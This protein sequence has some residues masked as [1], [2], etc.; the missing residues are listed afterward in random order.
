[1]SSSSKSSSSESKQ[2]TSN[3]SSSDETHATLKMRVIPDPPA[4][5]HP[6][7]SLPTTSHNGSTSHGSVL[8]AIELVTR[9]IKVMMES[10]CEEADADADAVWQLNELMLSGS[11]GLQNGVDGQ[12]LPYGG[13]GQHNEHKDFKMRLISGLN[14]CSLVCPASDAVCCYAVVIT[15]VLDEWSALDEWLNACCCDEFSCFDCCCCDVIWY[16]LGVLS[17]ANDISG[18]LNGLTRQTN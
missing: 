1:M 13:L 18:N 7:G 8:A 16:G 14:W 12:L 11:F 4:S 17:Q 3:S 15:L 5:W 10:G 6:P 9:S 2:S